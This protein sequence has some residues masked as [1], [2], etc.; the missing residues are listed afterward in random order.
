MRADPWRAFF[1]YLPKEST[2]DPEVFSIVEYVATYPRKVGA[3]LA[4]AFS[5]VLST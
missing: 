1:I 4:S 2:F 5:L 3:S